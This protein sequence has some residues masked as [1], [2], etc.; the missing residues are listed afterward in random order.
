MYMEQTGERRVSKQAG[1]ALTRLA[2]LCQQHSARS[3]AAPTAAAERQHIHV[4][5]SAYFRKHCA[6]HPRRHPQTPAVAATLPHCHHY[7]DKPRARLLGGGVVYPPTKP[8]FMPAPLQR[9]FPKVGWLR[10]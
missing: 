10:A 7:P 2:V 8:V 6:P 3:A 9:P 1:P 5:A 4:Q